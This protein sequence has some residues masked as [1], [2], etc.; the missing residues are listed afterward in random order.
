M[1]E[2]DQVFGQDVSKKH[3]RSVEI[4]YQSEALSKALKHVSPRSFEMAVEAL[5]M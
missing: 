2:S 4:V 5:A 3:H 1:I